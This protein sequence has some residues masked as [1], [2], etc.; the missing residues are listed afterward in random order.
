M[1]IY[2][3]QAQMP[4]GLIKVGK[5]KD[6]ASRIS[7]LQHGMPFELKL[8]ASI[9][10]EVGHAEICIHRRLG[11]HRVR[12]EWFS[13]HPDVFALIAELQKSGLAQ[14]VGED[15]YRTPHRRLIDRL[16]GISAASKMLGIDY[17]TVE[18][19]RTSG[20]IHGKYLDIV[21]MRARRLGLD[22]KPED[23]F[24][25]EALATA[26]IINRAA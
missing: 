5:A 14:I 10:G 23:F 26:S 8:I 2:F 1:A 11:Q 20:Y 17:G 7:N 21:L 22:V 16:G 25:A 18:G 3:A 15:A 13:P 12:G 6:V 4:G 9:E 24:S 19:W